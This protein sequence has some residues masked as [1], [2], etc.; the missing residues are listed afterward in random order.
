MGLACC[1]DAKYPC[2][3]DA[4]IRKL[5]SMQQQMQ[6]GLGE[7]LNAAAAAGGGGSS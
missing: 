6:S 5:E 2:L 4:T 3:D 7:A 1:S